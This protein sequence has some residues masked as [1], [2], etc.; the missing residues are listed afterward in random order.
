[1]TLWIILGIALLIAAF[2][3]YRRISKQRKRRALLASSL[4]PKQRAVVER[5]VPLVRRLPAPVRSA[6]EGKI[7]LF[8]DQITFRGQNGLEV[9]EDMKLSIAAQ[10]CLLVVNSPV[11]YDTLRNVLIYPSAFLTNRDTHDGNFVH[12]NRHA[13]LGES[14]ARGPVILS[15]DH[16]L[17]GGLDAE[18]G[19]NVVIHEFAHQLDGLSGHT[20]GIPILRKGQAYAGWE[21]AMLDAFEDQV[22][23][24]EN[25]Q[26]TL[27]DP[28][29]ATSH[30]EFFA[31]AIVTFFERPRAM[32]EQMPALYDQLAKLLALDPAEWH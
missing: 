20:N 16:A 2:L 18:D 17:Q 22:Q 21:R 25:G 30:Q 31:E 32:R 8:L 7:N 24:V 26:P 29:G 1:M 12:E 11:W 6:L 19:H 15:W 28:Y 10:A 13:T 23:R 9:S 4:T 3:L 14:W 27:I 5:L